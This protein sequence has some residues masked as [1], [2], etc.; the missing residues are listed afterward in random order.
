MS[1][2]PP[3]IVRADT[4]QRRLVLVATL[5]LLIGGVLA[6]WRL[7][8]QLDT[9]GRMTEGNLTALAQ[10]ARALAGCILLVVGPS[11]IGLGL[12]CFRLGTQ[13]NRAERFPPPGTKVLWDT[14]VRTGSSARLLA[15]ILLIASVASVLFG[16][17]GMWYV[18][19]WIH[20]LLEVG[21]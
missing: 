13:I 19:R 10:K 16:T 21:S 1:Q 18:F 20:A 2:T 5:L 3:E 6:L 7:D 12:W 9:I 8:R 14:R 15:H 11:F 17:V 4:R